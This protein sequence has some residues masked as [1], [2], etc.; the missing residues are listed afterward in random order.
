[1]TEW[2]IE[3]GLDEKWGIEED[4]SFTTAQNAI[5]TFGI[6]EL[7]PMEYA[8]W[9]FMKWGYRSG[10]GHAAKIYPIVGGIA[11]IFTN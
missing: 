1:M 7:P 8:I 11:T 2:L 3:N 5:Y 6:H 9:V 10:G 4:K